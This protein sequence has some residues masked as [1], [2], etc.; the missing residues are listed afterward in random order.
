MGFFSNSDDRVL[1]TL[2]VGEMGPVEG[3]VIDND[4]SSVLVEF[5]VKR[6]PMLP[7]AEEVGL[8]LSV[9]NPAAKLDVQARVVVQSH[10]DDQIQ[11]RFRL[12]PKSARNVARMLRRRN[13]FRAQPDPRDPVHV[14]IH[15]S[16]DATSQAELCDISTTGAWLIIAAD[17]ESTLFREA[18]LRLS[19]RLPG[20]GQLFELFADIRTR[21]LRGSAIHYG[22]E[23]NVELTE[24]AALQAERISQYVLKRQLEVLRENAED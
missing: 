6:S 5:P 11:Y 14:L 24:R 13:A 19:F 3:L 7:I 16:S 1:A 22:L 9:T 8:S 23:F 17:D 21:A 15:T 2:T 18:P 12:L 4:Q 20:H 10:R